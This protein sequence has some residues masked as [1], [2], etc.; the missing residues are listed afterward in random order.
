MNDLYEREQAAARGLGKLINGGLPGRYGRA[1][2]YT[3]EGA[4]ELPHAQP[5]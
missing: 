4:R 2:G 3:R 5:I 1:A